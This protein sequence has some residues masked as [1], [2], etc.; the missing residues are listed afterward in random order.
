[1]PA[2]GGKKFNYTKA[3]KTA[4]TKMAK[5]TGLKVKRKRTSDK[6]VKYG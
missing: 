1:M 2:V 5:R 4:A 3:G 6:K